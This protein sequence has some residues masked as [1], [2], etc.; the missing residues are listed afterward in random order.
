[1]NAVTPAV[2]E[3]IARRGRPAPGDFV[4]VQLDT[5]GIAAGATEVFDCLRETVAAQQLGLLR[6]RP[7]RGPAEPASR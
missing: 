2:L 1:M 5:G 4:R 3:D 7:R 6:H